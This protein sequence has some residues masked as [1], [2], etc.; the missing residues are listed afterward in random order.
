MPTGRAHIR[1]D[2]SVVII[3]VEVFTKT[4]N[5]PLIGLER[6][7]F[8]L[9]E[10]GVPQKIAHFSGEDAPVS[11]GILV[12]HSGSMDRSIAVAHAGVAQFLK[13][14]NPADQFFLVTFETR[15]EL[16]FRFTNE[17]G[18]IQNALLMARPK[19]R[20]ALL[21][22]VY[23]GLNQMRRAVHERR[24]LLVLSDGADNSSRYTSL[25]V[26]NALRE[27]NVQIY[28]IGI[29]AYDNGP[30]VLSNLSE[31][32]GGAYFPDV[33]LHNLVDVCEKIGLELRHQYVLAYY[34]TNPSRDG[35]WRKV[36]VKLTPPRGLP[37]LV[38]H[39]RRGY[40]APGQ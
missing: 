31:E 36:S 35:K 7:H 38:T 2:S 15:P 5:Q 16:A 4:R 9:S 39:H 26:R 19:G 22:A 3:P 10:D 32:S 6:E 21:D 11:I 29:A 23:M 34:P 24:A 8:Q 33:N 1:A 27:T 37:P 17:P 25:E 40:Y 13:T 14:A 12:D 20:T 30:G 18:D 28:T